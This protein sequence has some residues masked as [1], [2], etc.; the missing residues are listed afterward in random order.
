MPLLCGSDVFGV[1][2]QL[3]VWL[4]LCI[5]TQCLVSKPPE[6]TCRRKNDTDR[7]NDSI[8][9]I[10]IYIMSFSSNNYYHVLENME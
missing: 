5:F 6:G 10:N 7:T 8:Y 9:Y 1:C 2:S 3:Y 4:Y